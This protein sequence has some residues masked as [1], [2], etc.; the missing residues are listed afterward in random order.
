MFKKS[1]DSISITR[2]TLTVEDFVVDI[3]IRGK[4]DLVRITI[5]NDVDRM[6]GPELFI[7]ER[8]VENFVLNSRVQDI[9]TGKWYNPDNIISAKLIKKVNKREFEYFSLVKNEKFH[10]YYT[11]E[12]LN[13][14]VEI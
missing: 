13:K 12:E 6:F 8:D 11:I 9:R 1:K 3:E 5:E 10:E 4:K 14:G 7:Q 2:H